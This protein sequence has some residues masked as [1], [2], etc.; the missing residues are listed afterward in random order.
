MADFPVP[1]RRGADKSKGSLRTERASGR[2]ANR[3]ERI[4]GQI[5]L[6]LILAFGFGLDE[7]FSEGQVPFAAES[8]GFSEAAPGR[9]EPPVVRDEADR[10]AAEKRL[11]LTAADSRRGIS[12]ET[13][14]TFSLHLGGLSLPVG[15]DEFRFVFH[16][17]VLRISDF[18][19]TKVLQ[20]AEEVLITLGGSSA[21]I[22][23]RF[24][25]TP[26]GS[27]C[28]SI[29]FRP[30]EDGLLER[31]DVESLRFP[32]DVAV[33][34]PKSR[35]LTEKIG[36]LPIC[37]FLEAG[38]HGAFLSLDFAYSEV[39][40]SSPALRIGYQP[41]VRLRKGEEY[42]SHSVTLRGYQIT[43]QRSGSVDAAAARS[44][45]DYIRWEYAPPRQNG[46]QLL[47]NSTV[48]RYTEI[49]PSVPPTPLGE[50]PISN[51]ISYTFQ[52]TP[53]YMINPGLIPGEIDFCKRLGFEFMFVFEGPFEWAAGNPRAAV[54]RR[55][56]DYA[57]DRG[58]KLCLYTA[59]NNLTA[60]HFNHYARDKGQPEWRLK[61]ENGETGPYCWGSTDFARW[62]ADV[63]IESS[64][65][66]NFHMANF[67]FLQIL[68]CF[69]ADHGHAPGVDGLYRQ[70]FNLVDTLDR[71]RASVPHYMYESNIG[72][73][74]LVP[75]VAPSMDAFYLTD[76][77]VSFY[78]PV[79]NATE[80]LDNSRRCQ[81][82][83]YFLNYLIPV[84]YFR[85]TEHYI[86]ADSVVHDAKIF[87]YGVLQSIALTPNLKFSDSRLLF[88]RLTAAERERATRF[89]NRWIRFL[90]DNV[91]F[92]ANTIPLVSIPGVGKLEIYAHTKGNRCF[93]FLVNPNPFG[94]SGHF[95]LDAGIGLPEEIAHY[96]VRE[97]YPEDRFVAGPLRIDFRTGETVNIVVS[98]R[99]VRVLE[100]GPPPKYTRRPLRIAG[101]PAVYDRFEDH[102]RVEVE[103]RQGESRAL[104]VYLPKAERLV[105]VEIGGRTVPVGPR[106]GGQVITVRFPKEEVRDEVLEWTVAEASL[107]RGIEERI[108]ENKGPS[109][110]FPLLSSSFPAANF[111]GAR[112]ENLVNER[113]TCQLRLFY[114]PNDGLIHPGTDV[115][116]AEPSPQLPAS[117]FELKG[118]KCWYWA[119]F[120]VAWVQTFTTPPLRDHNYISLNFRKPDSVVKIRA[121][122]NDKEA[123]VQEYRYWRAPTWARNFYIDGTEAGLKRGDN[124]LVLYVEY[125]D[126]DRSSNQPGVQ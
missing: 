66:F 118:S 115:P 75:K 35:P 15:G 50:R 108:W 99:S 7:S 102:Y 39:E 3:L 124:C 18:R 5:C 59:A 125:A 48:N 77:H 13:G 44:F 9:R 56:G 33:T 12:L 55:I 116:P 30:R 114:A 117:S 71:V 16:G 54:A 60:P 36:G 17:T 107:D 72:W 65:N 112:I 104:L 8:H 103:G 68:P 74:P 26:L 76:P 53:Y 49:D 119:H 79:L 57:R 10:T 87:E 69:A 122:L 85:N 123:G 73:P 19:L 6:L 88:D 91:D 28:K 46:P 29:R 64:R 67:D 20:S 94:V 121:W 106:Q 32:T 34:I 78:F 83:S 2:R 97:L 111:L 70:V 25:R 109:V 93:I 120:P 98:P 82:L 22:A 126:N 23:L 24:R 43:G 4:R 80:A 81:M 52:N 84:E 21:D 113:F 14:R 37:A 100:I 27:L 11:D 89:V 31:V 58:V 42:E 101:A 92:Y 86:V 96:Q 51:T 38:G 90:K 45:R 61:H 62:F 47:Y 110:R 41:Y 40:F 95:S 63:L 105:R 1:Q